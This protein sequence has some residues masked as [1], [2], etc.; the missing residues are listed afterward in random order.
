MTNESFW[1][2]ISNSKKYGAEQ[3][4]WLTQELVK[5]N[6]EDIIEFEIMFRKNMEQSSI[7]E[8]R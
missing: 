5:R 6:T 4:E 8:I 7:L 1:E 2:L 3:V